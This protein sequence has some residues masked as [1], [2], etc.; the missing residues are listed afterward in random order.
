[1]RPATP[2]PARVRPNTFRELPK[3][4]A[5]PAPAGR[6]GLRPPSPQ[7]A[8]GGLSRAPPGASPR[9]RD[10]PIPVLPPRAAT[11]FRP[12]TFLPAR[13]A[14][15]AAQSSEPIGCDQRPRNRL[16][17]GRT[18]SASCRSSRRPP[19]QR[20]DWLNI[21]PAYGL[22]WTAWRLRPKCSALKCLSLPLEEQR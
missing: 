20:L 6:R 13:S 17:S 16:A 18:P 9:W 21:A 11:G 14:S 5:S 12:L 10:R 2:Q 4:E 8:P 3:F 1:L 22:P 19:L 7:E 15:E